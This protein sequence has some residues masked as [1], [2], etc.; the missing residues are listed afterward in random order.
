MRSQIR[1]AEGRDAYTRMVNL[2]DP[3]W[4]W[5]R[6]PLAN[7]DYGWGY[8]LMP[9]PPQPPWRLQALVAPFCYGAMQ[10]S[11]QVGPAL[12]VVRPAPAQP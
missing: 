10:G 12:V 8:A 7:W 11:L 3:A 4:H 6:M 2:P 5:V 1:D 9:P